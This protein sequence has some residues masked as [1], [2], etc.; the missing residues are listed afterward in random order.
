M[1]TLTPSPARVPRDL[2]LHRLAPQRP[3][4]P[5]DLTTQVVGLGAL[6]LALHALGPGGEELLTPRA[7]QTVGDVM[8]A[9][10]LG[11]R[12]RTTQRR[13]H[14]LGLLLHGEPPVLANLAQ[15]RLLL[16]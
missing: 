2:D 12:R 5:R 4:Q 6:A 10:E 13:E 3:L 15:R 16:G 1:R 8:L 11:D 7:Q 14:D 9:T